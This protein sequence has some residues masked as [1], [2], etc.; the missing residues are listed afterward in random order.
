MTGRSAHIF[1]RM[2]TALTAAGLIFL[3]GQDLTAGHIHK[4]K[5][6]Q[7]VWCRRAGGEM[8]VR[9]NDKTRVDCLTR[10]YAVEVD[11]GPKW[12]EA[13]GQ[14]LYYSLKTGKRGG[15][16]LILEKENDEVYLQRLKMVVEQ[17]GLEIKIWS[18]R[19][20]DL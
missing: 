6:Y 3:P 5:V 10:E 13:I 18:I 12:A 16:V 1:T 20:Q 14:S 4:E 11:F 2:L 19:P 7:T 15:V 8:E 9:Q 17:Y